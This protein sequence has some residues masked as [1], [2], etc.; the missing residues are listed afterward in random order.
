VTDA[1]P[2]VG[3]G[4]VMRCLTLAGALRRA[5]ATCAFSTTDAVDGVLDGF[6]PPQIVRFHAASSGPAGLCAAA[7]EA[8]RAWG[9]RFAVVDHYG[10]GAAEDAALRG[11]AGRLLAIEDL[12]RARACD[13]LLDPSLGRQA[14]DYVGA[15][16]LTGPT[17]ALVRPEFAVARPAALARRARADGVETVLV[18]LGLTD[19]GAITWRVVAALA[20]VLGERRLTVALGSAA[21]SLPAM[22]TLAAA[23]PRIDLHVDARDMAGLAARADLAIGAGG[24]SAWER[25]VVGLPTI[26]LVLADNQRDNSLALDAAGAGITLEVN[27]AIDRRL[28]EAF[29]ALAGDLARRAAMGAAAAALCDG[30]GADR[31]AARMLEMA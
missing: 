2:A 28:V 23:D 24:S 13:L 9:A 18:S 7:A 17:F 4:H 29:E 15:E 6:A 8:A 21:P 22:Q 25:C 3:G 20:P 31:V 30:L 11:A 5:G 19:V 16:S 10:A 12:G 27:R 14:G 26:A 1:G